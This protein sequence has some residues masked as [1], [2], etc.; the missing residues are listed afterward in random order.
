MERVGLLRRGFVLG[1]PLV[2]FDRERRDRTLHPLRELP[3]RGPEQRHDRRYEHTAD[4]GGSLTAGSPFITKARKTET[5]MITV[6]P[7]KDYGARGGRAGDRLARPHA[8]R[9]L[10]TVAGEYKQG[11]IDANT[12]PDH[13]RQ[14]RR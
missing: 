11:V 9:E 8:I 2:A 4:D 5:M 1:E 7:G 10:A 13:R 3:A 12:Q 14:G 6:P